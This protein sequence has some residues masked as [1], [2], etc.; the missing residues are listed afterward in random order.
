MSLSAF[1]VLSFDCYG[2]LVDWETGIRQ[3]L[4]ELAARHLPNADIEQLATRCGFETVANLFDSNRF[5][6]NSLWKLV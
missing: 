2:T 5:Y 3:V 6:T 1:E 4:S